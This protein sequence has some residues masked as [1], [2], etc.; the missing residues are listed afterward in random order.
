MDAGLA[1]A[2][3]PPVLTRGAIKPGDLAAWLA[4]REGSRHA[5][6][7]WAIV[8]VE[9]CRSGRFV[10][11]VSS[12]ADS[13][14]RGARRVLLVGVTG[15]G[16]DDA[17]PRLGD[18]RQALVRTLRYDFPA[19][20]TIR[21]RD[22]AGALEETLGEA[23]VR[24]M[25][26]LGATL[27][28]R[29]SAPAG[30]PVDVADEIRNALAGLT[31]AERL[32]FVPKAQGG[33]LGEVAWY[34]E[35]RDAERERVCRWLRE[36]TGGMFVVTGRPGSGKSAFLGNL[37]V[38]SRP[39]LRDVLVRRGLVAELPASRRPA[40][41]AF[42]A[43]LHLTGATPEEV[44]NRINELRK[45]REHLTLLVDALDEAQQPLVIARDVLRPLTSQPGIRL[46]IGTR[47]S[48]GSG[49][50]AARPGAPDLRDAL[51]PPE[52]HVLTLTTDTEAIYRY[53][54]RRLATTL[55]TGA[56]Q[57]ARRVART[58]NDFLYSRLAIHEIQAGL[59]EDRL[60]A[61]FAW[62]YRA[63][64][65]HAVARLSAERR[66]FGPLLEALG[67]A[68]GR[69]LP[70]IDSLWATVAGTLQA[71][72]DPPITDDDIT[73]LI[74]AAS[75]HLMYDVEH[76]Q[77]VYRLAHATFAEHFTRPEPDDRHVR[78]TAALV[79][80]DPANPYL[81]HHLS[82]HAAAGG[83]PAWQTLA[84]HPQVLDR[85]APLSTASRALRSSFGAYT[86]PPEVAGLVGTQH[87]SCED[88]SGHHRH[89]I[90]QLGA[91]RHGGLV[92]PDPADRPGPDAWWWLRWA[93]AT[94]Y[95]PHL[96]LVGHDGPVNAVTSLVMADGR[97]LLASASDDRTVRLWDVATGVQARD[98]LTHPVPVTSL[99]A[100][101]HAKGR[102]LLASGDTSGTVWIWDPA[103][104][105]V[106]H[107]L[108]GDADQYG[109]VQALLTF[110]ASGRLLL[111]VLSGHKV[112]VWDPFSGIKEFEFDDGWFG[113]RGFSAFTDVRGRAL[114]AIG[115]AYGKISLWEA[116]TGAPAGEINVD[117]TGHVTALAAFTDEHGYPALAINA[118]R[119][120]NIWD[121]AENRLAAKDVGDSMR[122]W[123][124]ARFVGPDGRPWL[125]SVGFDSFIGIWNLAEHTQSV[126]ETERSELSDLTV[127]AGPRRNT[128]LATG[129]KD[130]M[131][132]IWDPQ[133]AEAGADGQRTTRS[134]GW[135][136][137]GTT[138]VKGSAW[139]PAATTTPS[140]SGTLLTEQS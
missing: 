114:L 96:T 86:L 103:D 34:F 12:L 121:L 47:E 40:D 110:S 100:V 129:S 102:A 90:R 88:G 43:V 65:G 26:I 75:P 51:A 56:E 4:E 68:Q 21:L 109:E 126:I 64:F 39:G 132:R 46:L 60:D 116:L 8:V 119:G 50:D 62:D 130:G 76:G 7:T 80:A 125:A 112:R 117:T 11:L 6:G 111:A 118:G 128:L 14:P 85:P 97:T 42:D 37:V 25:R 2:A 123:S 84:D 9:A 78:I 59:R 20:D 69:G 81:V 33:E 79:R 73:D 107:A 70:K 138:T 29:T 15:G 31:D 24:P 93:R 30:L 89:G 61:L 3:S 134:P 1:H 77:T 135:P 82:G 66:A 131:L 49:P 58:K 13:D 48:T 140:G 57:L 95:A 99:A 32:H 10:E 71:A 5:E 27:E 101:S 139:R 38:H 98:P 18:F 106:R 52:D 53:A 16:Q 127:F 94:Q 122:I 55:P 113:Q 19:N 108:S 120:L 41:D 91:A 133:S 115:S 17:S 136:S 104:G 105:S 44:T 92:I 36:S 137:S 83:L 54:R 87:L 74:Q 124:F 72:E 45:D 67:L 35:G 23:V 22:L 63:L 28:R